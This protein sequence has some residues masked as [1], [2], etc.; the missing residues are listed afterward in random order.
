MRFEHA[1]DILANAVQRLLETL[2]LLRDVLGYDALDDDARLVQHRTT[3]RDTG[4]E[5]HAIDAQRQQSQP[6]DL[7]D[8]VGADDVTGR[9][10]L[11]QDH[12]DGLQRLD[13]LLVVLAP[14]AVLHDQ[15]AEHATGAQDRH[16][17]ER[18]VDLLARLGTVGELG[19]VLCVVERQRTAATISLATRRTTSPSVT[20]AESARAIVSRSRLRSIRGPAGGV[21]LSMVRP[22]DA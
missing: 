15:Y 14:R 4:R 13:L 2:L 16:A 11:R 19:M 21:D 7:L 6:V 18:M 3:D 5:L 10:Q 9:D 17:G 12:G 22:L 8:L 20:S 1:V